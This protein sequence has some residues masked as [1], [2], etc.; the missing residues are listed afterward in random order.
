[1]KQV[2]QRFKIAFFRTARKQWHSQ[3][4][5][6]ISCDRDTEHRSNHA[7]LEMVTFLNMHL[8]CLHIKDLPFNG[9]VSGLQILYWK[10]AGF[11]RRQGVLV[12]GETGVMV[13]VYHTFGGI[14]D[15]N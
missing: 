4:S 13:P 3:I 11:S 12:T 6:M 5:G 2:K 10:K 9:L 15:A 7:S 14:E 1:M 8:A